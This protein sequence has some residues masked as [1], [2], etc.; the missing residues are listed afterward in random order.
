[1][2]RFFILLIFSIVALG[3]SA[4]NSTVVAAAA[5]APEQV[6]SIPKTDW[7]TTFHS[8]KI[9]GPMNV[10]FKRVNS[11]EEVRIIYDTKGYTQ[12]GAFFRY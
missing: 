1:M 11:A 7:L 12:Q 4:Q 10:L 5:T 3:A 2:K 9:D 8:I 6:V